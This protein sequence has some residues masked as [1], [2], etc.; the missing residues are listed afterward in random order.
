LG[1]DTP[2]AGWRLWRQVITVVP[3]LLR[4]LKFGGRVTAT[5]DTAG[6]IRSGGAPRLA[7][8]AC[9]KSAARVDARLGR[10]HFGRCHCGDRPRPSKEAPMAGYFELKTAGGSKPDERDLHDEGCSREW[11]RSVTMESHRSRPTHLRPRSRT[12][13]GSSP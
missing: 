1:G 3:G 12:W 2:F 4:P 11:N 5:W 6:C 7:T 9:S 10:G 8:A 13:P